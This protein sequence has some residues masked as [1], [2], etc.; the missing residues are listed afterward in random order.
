MTKY[1][2]PTSTQI[3]T[4]INVLAQWGTPFTY[5]EMQTFTT[6]T[7][8]ALESYIWSYGSASLWNGWVN[9]ANW[10]STQNMSSVWNRIVHPTAATCANMARATEFAGSV[11]LIFL[12]IPGLEELSGA[13]GVVAGVNG[14][15]HSMVC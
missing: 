11:G 10:F 1:Q 13:F 14:L 7:L 9:A 12:V 15:M 5:S 8:S 4:L 6:T 3:N 2:P